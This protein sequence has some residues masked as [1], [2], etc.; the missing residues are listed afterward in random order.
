MSS[1]E[2]IYLSKSSMEIELNTYAVVYAHSIPINSNETILW[3]TSNTDIVWVDECTGQIRANGIGE[4]YITVYVENDPT[5]YAICH[6]TVK[7]NIPVRSISFPVTEFTLL[8][9]KTTTLGV[10]I[11]PSNATNQNISWRSCCPEIATVSSTGNIQAKKPG[12][13]DIY[14][15]TENGSLTAKCTIHVVIDNVTIKQ[16]GIFLEI[17]FEDSGKTWKSIGH[18]MIY[19]TDGDTTFLMGRCDH[20]YFKYLDQYPITS[21]PKE[22]SDDELRL[23]YAID[24]YG[25]AE[26]IYRYADRIV[27]L[28]GYENLD[29]NACPG[30]DQEKGQTPALT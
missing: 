14:A 19:G 3:K 23:L 25:V 28:E 24:P 21:E 30:T 11:E 13:V 15:T 7:G 12:I 18:D 6:I 17:T 27:K 9:G 16:Q 4:A 20:N 2:R 5:V 10:V 29:R 26:Y 22:Y 8:E 1:V